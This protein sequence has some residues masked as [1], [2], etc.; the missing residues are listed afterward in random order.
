MPCFSP[1]RPKDV[2]RVND[3]Y[4][5]LDPIDS[6]FCSVQGLELVNQTVN[7]NVVS[8]AH[9]VT[10]TQKRDLNPNKFVKGMA[11]TRFKSM[12]C[13]V[14]LTGRVQPTLQDETTSDKVTPSGQWLWKP[15]QKQL[16]EGGFALPVTEKGGRKGH[17]SI[18]TSLLQ[19]VIPS[20]KTPEPVETNFRPKHLKF[21]SESGHVQTGNTRDHQALLAG[22]RLGHIPGLQRCVFSHSHKSQIQKVSQVSPKRVNFSVHGSTFWPRDGSI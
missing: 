21:V 8:H 5:V 17:G 2:N 16:S 11:L 6:Q 22:G 1:N 10:D 12:W 13:D 7:C 4:H 3:N 14:H 9:F 20:P 18:L 15:S 19:L